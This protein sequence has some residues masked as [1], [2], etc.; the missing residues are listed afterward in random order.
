MF[1]VAGGEED[2]TSE[3]LDLDTLTWRD[4]PRFPRIVDGSYGAQFGD[5]FVVVYSSVILEFDPEN[6]AWI[7]RPETLDPP[8]Y[9][10]TAVFVKDKIV[11]CS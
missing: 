8:R 3:I 4:G 1:V 9:D 6:E 11:N 2:F 10:M 5:T 7:T